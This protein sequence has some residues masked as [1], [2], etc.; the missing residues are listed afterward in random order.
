MP[1]Y[2]TYYQNNFLNHYPKDNYLTH[3]QAIYHIDSGANLYLTNTTSDLIMFHLTKR[4]I[5]FVVGSTVVC[6]GFEVGLIKSTK[7]DPPGVLTVPAYYCLTAKISTLSPGILKTYN[8]Y[9][10]VNIRLLKAFEIILT[11]NTDVHIFS[12]TV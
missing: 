9:H 10:N 12:T 3:Q 7:L 1:K 2:L 4:N 11:A 6:E 8:G 5:N